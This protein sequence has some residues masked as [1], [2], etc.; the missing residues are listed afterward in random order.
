[1]DYKDGSLFSMKA[2]RKWKKVFT[3]K[4]GVMSENVYRNFAGIESLSFENMSNREQF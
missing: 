4:H 1:M 3:S 2:V